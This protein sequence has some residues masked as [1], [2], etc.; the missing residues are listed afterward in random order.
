MALAFSDGS[1]DVVDCGGDGSLDF[2]VIGAL[3]AWIYPTS[4][5]NNHIIVGRSVDGD[6]ATFFR[7]VGTSG[8]FGFLFNRAGA[9]AVSTSNST[10]LVINE[11]NFVAALYNL[12]VEAA[13]LMH[14][15]L[16]ILPTEVSGY[17]T[18]VQG[19]GA[20]RQGN[21]ANVGIGNIVPGGTGT[22]FA[23]SIAW[24]GLYDGE[25]PQVK[26]QQMW[27]ILRVAGST[28]KLWMPL[29]LIGGTGTQP[30]FSGFGNNGATT[31]VT[32]SNNIIPKDLWGWYVDA[33]PNFKFKKDSIAWRKRKSHLIYLRR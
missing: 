15:T 8:D 16:D 18:Q 19:S 32:K 20:A 21:A 10:P 5:A 3:V 1:T 13:D 31:G 6:N 33:Y 30:D 14:G 27:D 24:V 12:A 2:G 25:L 28:N 29:G 26:V 4:F 23:G 11:W 17:S 9:N 7:L 22:S